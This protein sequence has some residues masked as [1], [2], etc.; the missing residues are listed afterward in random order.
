MEYIVDNSGRYD[1]VVP[2]LARPNGHTV[3]HTIG[4]DYVYGSKVSNDYFCFVLFTDNFTI[5]TSFNLI[6]C[7]WHG[8][9]IPIQINVYLSCAN[10]VPWHSNNPV[11]EPG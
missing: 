8:I 3:K 5:T 6:M 9:P 1:C 7:S 11:Q 10:L 4:E 2:C